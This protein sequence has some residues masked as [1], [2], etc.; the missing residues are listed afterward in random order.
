MKRDRHPIRL[1]RTPS[2]IINLRLRIIRQ[3]R[4]LDRLLRHGAQIPNQR[5]TIIPRGTNMTTRMRRP[6]RSIHAP[7][8]PPQLR[9]RH[10]RH[11]YIQ[12]NR[13]V[14]VHHEGG[15]VIRILL[16][17]LQPQQGHE[18]LTLVHNG[19]MFQT[20]QIEHPDATVRTDGRKH[21]LP[22]GERQIENLPIVSDELRL[23]RLRRNVP[24]RARRVD[25]GRPD[26]VR[27]GFV[28]IKAGEGG[29][30]LAVFV[31]VQQGFFSVVEGAA[32]RGVVGDVPQAEVVAGGG[33]EVAGVGGAVGGPEDF[34]AGV[35]MVEFAGFEDLGVG[36]VV[37][38]GIVLVVGGEVRVVGGVWWVVMRIGSLF[39]Y[40][41][42]IGIL[43]DVRAYC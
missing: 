24:N 26:D 28:P 39:D 22:P 14:G 34:G 7:T 12:N 15:E 35:G 42:G 32:A 6:R 2:Q 33:E 19:G 38:M 11:P 41:D 27:I 23:G 16:V 13:P 29:A 25:R 37:V 30:V 18:V 10:A 43:F 5:L 31:V 21:V 40:L 4:I 8:M 9:H 20:S 1:T 36:G 3:N 17:P